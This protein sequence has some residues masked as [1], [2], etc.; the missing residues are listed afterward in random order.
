MQQK[1]RR[2][3][4]GAPT[5]SRR[6]AHRAAKRGVLQ[7]IS[8]IAENSG[9]AAMVGVLALAGATT[10]SGVAGAVI[11]AQPAT[12]STVIGG[13]LA[14]LVN[15]AAGK[16][17]SVQAA[18]VPA[19]VA[20]GPQ[21]AATGPQLAPLPPAP[22][23][24]RS[25]SY[26]PDRPMSGIM[27]VSGTGYRLVGSDGGVYS[28]GA[29]DTATLLGTWLN[30]RI[31]GSATNGSSVWLAGSDGG[32]FTV[33][34]AG[35]YG[36]EGGIKLNG[37]IVGMAATPS[38]H[39]YYLV[40]RDGGVF[41]FGD[42]RYFGSMGGHR[43]NGQVVGMAVDPA[44]GGYWLVGSDGGIFAF[45]AP[46]FGSLGGEKLNGRIVG[47][48]ATPSG[49]GYYLVGSDGG[50]FTFGGAPYFGSLGGRKLG[51]SVVGVATTQSGNGYWLAGSDGGVFTFG[52]APYYGSAVAPPPPPPM[53][54]VP[55]PAPLASVA[56]SGLVVP[57][58]STGMDISRYQCGA[59]P[60]GHFAIS[61]V[62]VTGGALNWPANPCYAA[63]AAWAGPNL[64]SYIFMD[65]LPNPLPPE[66]MSGPAGVCG[67]NGACLAYNY[68]W[69]WADHW[70]AYSNSLGFH[71]R[72]W[73]L[74]IETGSGWSDA[75]TND[76][77]I[78][79]ALDAL[80]RSGAPYG[81][82][83]SPRQWGIITGGWSI[84]GI[85][86]WV[87]GA[88]NLSGPGF[89]A[90]SFCGDPSERFAGGVLRYVQYGYKGGFPGSWPG[91]P[92]RYDLDYAC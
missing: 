10:V 16:S 67:S 4:S 80:R 66:A 14:P 58:G 23:N 69:F 51:G 83:S 71:A 31:V 43:L 24:Q 76:Q 39:G 2:A 20:S 30:G 70:V 72:Q 33:G 74:D 32:V 37:Q 44:T 88:G 1:S 92:S 61:V 60:G 15:C 87:P 41:T 6:R 55:L 75:G 11:L 35:F 38:G 5:R 17:T 34:G 8:S 62:Q 7:G 28:F 26:V 90:T 89:T 86:I 82:Y 50:V 21:G 84:P 53:P 13:C 27:N 19:P 79:G 64:Q 57:P 81:I 54:P 48:S 73:W 59:I 42:A 85:Q 52:D 91:P 9:S 77:V 45:N 18:S 56:P 22:V 40:G 65:G 46:Y 68:G 12:A 47:I 63:E 78:R 25:I 3:A 49:N 36:S 29:P